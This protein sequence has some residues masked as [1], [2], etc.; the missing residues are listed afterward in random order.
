MYDMAKYNSVE[1]SAFELSDGLFYVEP[2]HNNDSPPRWL[3]FAIRAT[4]NLNFLQPGNYVDFV[5]N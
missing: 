5:I 2:W 4:E 1:V 3:G